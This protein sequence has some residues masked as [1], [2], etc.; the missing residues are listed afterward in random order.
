[1]LGQLQMKKEDLASRE[2]NWAYRKSL[3]SPDNLPSPTHS[4]IE[5]VLPEEWDNALNP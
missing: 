4:T 1:M 3:P 2:G 5:D